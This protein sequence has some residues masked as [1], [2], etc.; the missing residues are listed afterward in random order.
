MLS[1]SPHL[2][3]QGRLSAQWLDESDCVGAWQSSNMAAA[4]FPTADTL[5][6]LQQLAGEQSSHPLTPPSITHDAKDYMLDFVAA[7]PDAA[8]TF[9]SHNTDSKV[10]PLW[11]LPAILG[12]AAY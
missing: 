8:S 3:A 1:E 9:Q 10:L 12:A 5:P 6:Q 7:V 11:T 2:A 4:V